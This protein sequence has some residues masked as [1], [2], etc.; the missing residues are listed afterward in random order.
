[1]KTGEVRMKWEFLRRGGERKTSRSTA[2]EKK[3][4]PE[5]N[6]GKRAITERGN[7]RLLED[8]TRK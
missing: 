2:S 7:E 5:N 1:M 4:E 3:K 6:G 8:V